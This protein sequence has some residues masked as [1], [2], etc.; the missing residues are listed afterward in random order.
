MRLIDADALLERMKRTS[1]YFNVKFDIEDAPT[2][3]VEPKWVRAEDRKPKDF[4]SVLGHMTDAGE[5]PSV[6]EC[7]VIDG[8]HFYFPALGEVH[9]VDKWMDMPEVKD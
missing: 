1:R 5:F 6:R 8:Q 7:Y 2:I 4:V 3:E 9:P